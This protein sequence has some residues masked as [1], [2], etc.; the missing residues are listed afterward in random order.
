MPI[1]GTC[2]R[3]NLD[4]GDGLWAKGLSTDGYLGTGMGHEPPVS[5]MLA[6]RI[7]SDCRDR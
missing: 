6:G 2:T 5:M 3:T 7:Y 4:A 1:I